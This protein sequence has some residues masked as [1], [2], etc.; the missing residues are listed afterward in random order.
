MIVDKVNW[1]RF[2]IDLNT[3]SEAEYVDL[4]VSLTAAQC[5]QITREATEK[6]EI[7]PRLR[8]VANSIVDNCSTQIKLN[9][10]LK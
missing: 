10:G 2:A 1:K 7:N 9:F 3:G 6:M 8:P 4:A 5:I